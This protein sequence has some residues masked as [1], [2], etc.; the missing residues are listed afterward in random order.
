MTRSRLQARGGAVR[1]IVPL[2]VACLALA[3]LVVTVN[4]SAMLTAR[5]PDAAASLFFANAGARARLAQQAL[6][7][8][9]T[10]AAAKRAIALAQDAVARDPIMP[11]ALSTAGLGFELAGQ[12]ER[13][14][15]V[16]LQADRL[17]RRV[18]TVQLWLIEDA[19]RR[20]DVPGALHRYDVALRT[21]RRAS[22]ILFPI[23]NNVTAEE[24]MLRPMARLLSRDPAWRSEFTAQLVNEGPL[25]GVTGLALALAAQGSPLSQDYAS[26]LMLRLSK[27]RDY[28]DLLAVFRASFPEEARNDGLLRD[29]DFSRPGTARPFG[30]QFVDGSDLGVA[31]SAGG[32]AGAEL[33]ADSGA[34]GEAARQLVL[35]SPGT[36]RLTARYADAEVPQGGEPRWQVVCGTDAAPKLGELPLT[37]LSGERVVG[38][39]FAVP[40]AGCPAQWVFLTVPPATSEQAVSVKLA[41]LSIERAR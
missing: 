38:T 2:A 3:G 7:A 39:T 27:E 12:G 37:A 11:I 25:R 21:N 4:V 20:G 34:S 23:L 40:A 19:V 26:L 30:W 13:A 29:P 33:Y 31:R 18:L 8:E 17:S 10:P 41:A 9:Q 28:R 22:A 16:M 35:L 24:Q 32:R 1:R 5:A 36:Y 14:R 6:V 15:S